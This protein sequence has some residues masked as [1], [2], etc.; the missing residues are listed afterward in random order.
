MIAAVLAGGRSRRM[1]SAKAAVLL[2]GRPLVAWPLAAAA[3]A[4][5]EGVV[6]A[7][8]ASELPDVG[9]PVWCEPA[10]PWHPLAGL[11]CALERA[12]A[13]V[14]ALAC[15]MPFVPAALIGELAAAGGT[16]AVR[17]GGRL[18]PFPGRYDLAALPVLSAALRREAAAT[19][20]L[21]ALGPLEI[22]ADERALAGINTPGELAEAERSMRGTSA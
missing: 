7:K 19:E 15:D 1:G 22:A 4:G 21:A 2:G 8:A 16:A 18:F 10:A 5:L 12:G 3:E 17:A 9:V 20:A 6:V 13:P 14:V 11:V